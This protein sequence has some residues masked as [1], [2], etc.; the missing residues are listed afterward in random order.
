[1]QSGLNAVSYYR[2]LRGPAVNEPNFERAQN[3]KSYRANAG[4]NLSLIV[5]R[6]RRFA[7]NFS[8]SLELT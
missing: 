8:L 6:K 1:M 7:C 2:N 4:R 5:V 3:F